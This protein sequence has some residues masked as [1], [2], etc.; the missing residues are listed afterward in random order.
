MKKQILIVNP[1]DFEEVKKRISKEGASRFHVISDFDRTITYGLSGE[2]K[3]TATVISQLRANP[4]YLGEGYQ[5]EA[6]RL[7]DIYHPIE[8]DESVELE[9]KKKKMHE[10]WKKHFELIA[11]SG[12]TEEIIKKVAKENLLKFRKGS[13]EFVSFLNEHKVPLVFMSAAPGD[14]L[15]EYLKQNGLMTKNVYVVSNRYKFDSKG[16]AIKIQEPIIHTFNKT[17]ITLEN[18]PV[19]NIIK[20]RKN[21]LLLGDSLGDVGMIEGFSY[22]NLIK[23]GFLN[24]EVEKNL[25]DYKKTFDV[26]L[27]N[28]CSIYY[29]NGILRE[30]AKK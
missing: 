2:G 15:I 24:D 10:W 17:E 19:F 29:A 9:E 7:F 27:L 26:V 8:V 13:L 6:Y 3:R 12:L 5:K 21:V 1:N 18:Y 22:K 20:G 30:I 28:D 14:M 23:I 11:K 25:Q 16:R 4:K